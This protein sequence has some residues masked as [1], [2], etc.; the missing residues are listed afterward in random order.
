M[1][2]FKLIVLAILFFL[3][4]VLLTNL[5][6]LTPKEKVKI[7]FLNVGQGHSLLIQAENNK[8][9][10]IDTGNEKIALNSLLNELSFFNKKI[11]TIF[12]T[13]YDLD[14]IG[15]LPFYLNYFQVKNFYDTGIKRVGKSQEGLYEEIK[16][17]V[18]KKKINKKELK[19][20]DEI[21]ISPRVKIKILFPDSFFNLDKMPSNDGSMV[22][23]IFIDHH[24]ILITGDLPK[25]YEKYLIKKYGGKLKSEILLAGHHGSRSSSSEDFLKTVNPK[26]FVIS[27]GEDNPY[28]HPHREILKLA[29][30][31]KLNIL[32]TD[33]L[34][35]INFEY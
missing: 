20:G 6:N 32:R 34:G 17:I 3:N 28:G 35:N 8:N 11:D 12:A 9:I 15:L 26:N 1:N 18:Q 21:T 22:L 4:L 25:K 23:M 13:H 19:A 24:K 14:H 31:L 33:I 30:K 5:N 27:V 16:K 7:T 2:F 10:L 29:K